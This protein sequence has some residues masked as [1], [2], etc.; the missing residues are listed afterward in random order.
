[1]KRICLILLPILLSI[2]IFG[3]TEIISKRTEYSKTYEVGNGVYKLVVYTKPIHYRNEFGKFIEISKGQSNSL[4]MLTQK[5][6]QTVPTSDSQSSTTYPIQGIDFVVKKY[7][8]SCSFPYYGDNPYLEEWESLE[9]GPF[10]SRFRATWGIPLETFEPWYSW[11]Q[12]IQIKHVIDLLNWA[13]PSS[14]WSG[15]DEYSVYIRYLD[16]DLFFNTDCEHY[17]ICVDGDIL[18]QITIDFDNYSAPQDPWTF[19]KSPGDDLVDDLLS[20]IQSS[21]PPACHYINLGYSIGSTVY[22]DYSD[23]W[24]TFNDPVLEIT[25]TTTID[26][27]LSNVD[28]YSPTTNLG[29]T[30]TLDDLTTSGVIDFNGISSG[31][32]VS[33]T[34]ERNF[35]VQTNSS[36]L[37]GKKHIRWDAPEYYLL[38]KLNFE[39]PSDI[40]Y[41]NAYFTT[42]SSVTI[43]STENGQVQIHD[44]WYVTNEAT[45]TQPDC[46]QSITLPRSYPV[47]LNQ[48]QYFESGKPIYRLKA[49]LTSRV[50]DR[51]SAYNTSNQEVPVDASSQWV[52]IQN[53]GSRETKVVFKQAGV[54]VYANYVPYLPSSITS[55]T[56]I[57]G[58]KDCNGTVTISG[59]STVVT[60]AAGAEIYNGNLYVT[61]G[62]KIV[63]NG[64]ASN[65][66]KFIGINYFYIN[67]NG[68]RFNYCYF[69]GQVE[70]HGLDNQFVS[71]TF[72]NSVDY[73]FVGGRCSDN[74]YGSFVLTNCTF[75][76]NYLGGVQANGTYGAINSCTF[77]DN[78]GPGLVLQNAVIG[79]TV[80]GK[81]G[82][83]TNNYIH[84]NTQALTGYYIGWG[85]SMGTGSTLYLGYGTQK[86]LN[87]ISNNTRAD[88][89]SEIALESWSSR[90]YAGIGTS[91][92]GYNDIYCNPI[93]SKYIR[94]IYNLAQQTY[95][96]EVWHVPADQTYFLPKGAS[97]PEYGGLYPPGSF[98]INYPVYTT[99][100]ENPGATYYIDYSP[101]SYL[102]TK[103][104]PIV[105]ITGKNVLA[106]QVLSS[107]IIKAITNGD[108]NDNP[109]ELIDIK[110]S[111]LDLRNSI[112]SEPNSWRN[113]QRLLHL[114]HLSLDF[115]PADNLQEKYEIVSLMT[116]K[117]D[118]LQKLK[119]K[120]K[121]A[122]SALPDSIYQRMVLLGEVAMYIEVDMLLQSGNYREALAKIKQYDK[123]FENTDSRRELYLCKLEA[124]KNLGEYQ[125]ALE[126]LGEVREE[127]QA[128]ENSLPGYTP[129]SYCMI[130]RELFNLMGL[131]SIFVA[132]RNI[133]KETN[134]D[135]NL[136]KFSLGSNYPNPFNPTTTIPFDLP[137][138]SR[139]K[140]QVFDLA[141]RE[142][143]SPANGF[144][145]AGSHQVIFDGSG[146]PSGMYFIRAQMKPEDQRKDAHHFTS[147]MMLLK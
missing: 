33:I 7:D 25:Y 98:D 23:Y 2:S 8:G 94:Y 66:V 50:F 55:S 39:M 124:L 93:P 12:I 88:Y 138:V 14:G 100:T 43:S 38:K 47:F 3:K 32:T 118:N 92:G 56:T 82:Y 126:V 147:K 40:E 142:V 115:D 78:G 102:M 74:S 41:I 63:A 79:K 139:V 134:Y 34:P 108:S 128:D 31:T 49:T 46:Y 44:P 133:G 104:V 89:K 10:N 80:S 90:L 48:N 28:L 24:M 130:E 96:G 114:H 137:E 18:D 70:S 135:L 109:Q 131:D 65:P 146:L 112:K 99:Q 21:N 103:V 119:Q 71:S 11:Y 110:Q 51:W 45:L 1:M 91:N 136:T 73:G 60:I 36:V 144:Y 64:T 117:K 54:K 77:C 111:M 113:A 59:S 57:S 20:D 83:F 53:P 68:N 26:V 15:S 58:K 95:G 75:K 81:G 107:G 145:P 17:D 67:S 127:A 129:P 85:I 122:I 16:E 141:G 123:Y 84:D 9:T 121:K 116:E 69:N 4:N 72:D 22:G 120:G 76:E 42:Q 106:K 27:K 86:G 13:H 52:H 30:L 97:L 19:T 132:K 140:I 125:Q 62:A 61:N 5:R 29:G 6:A 35:N 87:R 143:A 101:L 37:Q 105:S